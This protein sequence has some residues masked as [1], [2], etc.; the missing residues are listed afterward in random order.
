MNEQPTTVTGIN[1]GLDIRGLDRGQTP[2]ADWLCSCGQHERATGGD[3]VKNLTNRVQAG[4]CSH[5]V[6]V[7][8]E[9]A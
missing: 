4:A 7:L 5:E 8:K 1:T 9:A 6:A 3:A 2:V